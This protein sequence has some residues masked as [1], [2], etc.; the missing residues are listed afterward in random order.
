MPIA[1]QLLGA[2]HS[3]SSAI[4]TSPLIWRCVPQVSALPF[5]S[6]LRADCTVNYLSIQ[7][8]CGQPAS[9]IP[10]DQPRSC[11]NLSFRPSMRACCTTGW[12]AGRRRHR[13]VVRTGPAAELNVRFMLVRLQRARTVPWFTA[14]R[15]RR[16][17]R[18]TQSTTLTWPEADGRSR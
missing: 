17:R 12:P 18:V 9:Q 16:R 7:Q 2:I 13:G 6:R 1:I 10:S 14:G 4:K 8:W 3:L 5:S 15:R 11:I